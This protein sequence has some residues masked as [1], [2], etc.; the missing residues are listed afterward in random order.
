MPP[1]ILL[2]LCILTIPSC[3]HAAIPPRGYFISCG[4][5]K[6]E[7]VNGIKWIP[8]EGFIEVGNISK[9]QNP[10]VLPIL[11]SLRYFPDKSARKFCYVIPVAKGARYLVRTTYYYG[12]FDSNKEP[13]VFD[14][15]IDG[16][17]WSSVDTSA[18]YANGLTSYFE[19]IVSA[20]GKE[21]SVCLGRNAQTVSSPFISALELMQLDDSM[22]NSTDFSKYML[23]TIARHSFGHDGQIMSYPDDPFNR[24]WEPFLDEN[25]VV[26]CQSNV[27]SSDFWNL[28]PDTAFQRALTTSRGKQLTVKWPTMSLPEASYYVALYFQDNRNPSPYSW[29][30]FDVSINGENFYKGINASSSGVMVYGKQWP[31]S[32]QTKMVLS[33]TADSPVGPVINAGEILQIVPLGGRTL[34]RDAIAMEHLARSFNNPPSDWRG[35]PCFPPENS[36]T[37]VTCTQ[38]IFGRVSKLNLTNFGI[39]GMISNSIANLTAVKDIWLGGNKLSGQIPNLSSLNYL[40]SLHLENNELSGPI[41]SSLGELE[42][43]QELYLQNNKFEGGL[44][45]NLKKRSGIE[46]Q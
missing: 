31:L 9:V 46:I 36:W 20:K 45:D 10:D 24:Y 27:S 1:S 15:I 18:N 29:R 26:E 40:V 22:Y 32:G 2:L 35:D 28:P 34:T 6:E 16:T 14:Q 39:S 7:T 3:L 43:L 13:P 42:S 12:N 8:D 33:P 37:G 25:P 23:S 4:A 41:P 11:S 38:G 5:T 17:K 44:P 21:L 19:I 30:M